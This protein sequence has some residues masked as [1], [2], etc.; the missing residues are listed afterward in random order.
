MYKD[1]E[2]AER[3]L[4]AIYRPT[5]FYCIHVD[6]NASELVKE[7]MK[8]IVNCFPNVFTP[9]KVFAIEWGTF[10]V[11]GADLSCMGDLL[12]RPRWRYFINLTGQEYPLKTNLE[13]VRILKIMN[14]AN[15]VDANSQSRWKPRRWDMAGPPPHNISLYKGNVHV[16]VNRNFVDYAINNPIAKEFTRWLTHTKVPD[17]TFFATLN[18]NPQLGISGSS[19]GPVDTDYDKK[20]Y[21]ARFKNWGP[22]WGEKSF[23]WPCGGGR[24][25]NVCV[26]GVSD[27]PLLASR[28][29]LFANKFYA[30]YQPQTLDC[31]EE[32]LKTGR[33]SN[34]K[35]SLISIIHFTELCLISSIFIGLILKLACCRMFNQRNAELNS[36]SISSR[37]ASPK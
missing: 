5:N 28:R 12:G 11:L 36:V 19:T 20:P 29:E 31:V 1:V 4:R 30:S 7:N 10:S 26:F 21:I 24:S 37:P 25:R 8:R 16:A 2:Q 33:S 15:I 17:E 18:H 6:K 32:R 27:L 35:E 9:E 34:I 22:G 23:D 13:I 3:L 14:G